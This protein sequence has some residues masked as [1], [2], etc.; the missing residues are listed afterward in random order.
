MLADIEVETFK[1]MC[2]CIVLLARL[3]REIVERQIKIEHWAERRRAR[4]EHRTRGEVKRRIGVQRNSHSLR[5][6]SG[7]FEISTPVQPATSRLKVLRRQHAEPGQALESLE[8][9]ADNGRRAK[10]GFVN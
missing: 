6:R 9:A 7:D 3:P 5:N 10:Q 2:W 4:P 8:Y 1:C